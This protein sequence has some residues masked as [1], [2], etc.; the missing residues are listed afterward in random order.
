MNPKH[1]SSKVKSMGK[2]YALLLVLLLAAVPV[3]AGDEDVKE[4]TLKHERIKNEEAAPEPEVE[5]AAPE[6]SVTVQEPIPA[7]EPVPQPPAQKPVPPRVA[8][9]PRPNI[10]PDDNLDFREILSN[11]QSEELP[12]GVRQLALGTRGYRPNL[13]AF[14]VGDRTPG[15]GLMAEYNWN[16]IG[17][18]VAYSYRSLKGDDAYAHSQSF[19]NAYGYYHWLP[20]W[21]TPYF[22]IGVEK[23][24]PSEQSIGGLAG[25][26][27]ETQ[28]YR[29]WTALLGYT[30][31]SA[32]HR[33]FMGGSFGWAF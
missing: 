8:A 15:I 31:H 14:G 23:A 30:Y 13:V 3:W 25:V 4:E 17:V 7:P 32:V 22:L 19:V 24:L 18:G 16:R 5:E 2:G 10:G 12:M 28:I 11:I 21:I 33:G 27:V 20:F 26:G 9:P 1:L 6:P 29:G